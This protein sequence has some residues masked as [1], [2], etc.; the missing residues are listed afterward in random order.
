MFGIEVRPNSNR[1]DF[2]TFHEDDQSADL[3]A[4]D[5]FRRERNR[6]FFRGKMPHITLDAGYNDAQCE[7]NRLTIAHLDSAP[8]PSIVIQLFIHEGKECG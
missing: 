8:K 3:A 1:V 7:V 6:S 2:M 4:V 5:R